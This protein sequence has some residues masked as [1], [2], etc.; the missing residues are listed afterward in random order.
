MREFG[1]FYLPEK[2]EFGQANITADFNVA[3]SILTMMNNEVAK[4][5][6]ILDAFFVCV[7]CLHSLCFISFYL[8]FIVCNLSYLLLFLDYLR[9]CLI[10]LRILAHVTH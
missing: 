7:L 4:A 8:C 2:G 9:I 1:E 3:D 5:V 6:L 10:T